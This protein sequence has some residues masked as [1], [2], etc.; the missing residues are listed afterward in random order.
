MMQLSIQIH[1]IYEWNQLLLKQ[2]VLKKMKWLSQY[3]N[4]NVKFIEI[5]EAKLIILGSES[6]EEVKQNEDISE[7]DDT[8]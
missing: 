3:L 5:I 4:H 1:L 2:T 7:D 8:L 6:D